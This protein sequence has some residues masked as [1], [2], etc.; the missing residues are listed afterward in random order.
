[1]T[2]PDIISR[3]HGHAVAGLFV[4][5]IARYFTNTMDLWTTLPAPFNV[6]SPTQLPGSL[7]KEGLKY[8]FACDVKQGSLRMPDVTF[9]L[10]DV[11]DTTG[12]RFAISAL[13]TGM[14]A[15]SFSEL[16]ATLTAANVTS[17]SLKDT[18]DTPFTAPG[19]AYVNLEAMSFGS[20]TATA[21][22]T[23]V[24]GLY[25]SKAIT[26]TYD[27]DPTAARPDGGLVPEVTDRPVSWYG[28]RVWLAIAERNVS[29]TI[30]TPQIVW[31]GRLKG[32][33]SLAADGLTWELPAESIWDAQ[34]T[35]I[36]APA[37]ATHING[38]RLTDAVSFLL[39]SAG[40]GAILTIPAATYT[41]D[42]LLQVMQELIQAQ[43]D[44]FATGENH[45]FAAED[46]AIVS[47][48]V[49]PAGVGTQ[50]AIEFFDNNAISDKMVRAFF[51]LGDDGG[52]GD[53]ISLSHDSTAPKVIA[54]L[55][56]AVYRIST[57]GATTLPVEDSSL[58][59]AFEDQDYDEE[60]FHVASAVMIGDSAYRLTAVGAD[61]L[62][63]EPFLVTL[64]FEDRV[65]YESD[66]PTE[67]REG[68]WLEGSLWKY[69]KDGFVENT[70]VPAE[71]KGGVQTEDFD[72]T[73]MQANVNGG[74]STSRDRLI[75]KPT[76][77]KDILLED[78]AWSGLVPTIVDGLISCR[79]MQKA[80]AARVAVALDNDAHVSQ[81]IHS[82]QRSVGNVVNQI[83]WNMVRENTRPWRGA[84]ALAYS[85]TLI[86]NERTSQ[87]R[88]GGQV[89][90]RKIEGSG[91]RG[92]SGNALAE[93]CAGLA[94]DY[95]QLAARDYPVITVEET[96]I[97][98]GLQL[99]DSVYLSH[100]VTPNPDAPN[101]RGV[102]NA[103]CLVTGLTIAPLTG[104][105]EVELIYITDADRAG[106]IAPAARVLDY[107]VDAAIGAGYFTVDTLRYSDVAEGLWFPAN[108]KV[109]LRQWDYDAGGPAAES[110]TLYST[111]SNAAGDR[112]YTTTV[113]ANDPGTAG[114]TWVLTLNEYDTAAQVATAKLYIHIADETTGLIGTSGELG[115]KPG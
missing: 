94:I 111:P 51:G 40:N 2:W 69:L 37:P 108:A 33:L 80:S 71:W 43:I 106:G 107:V 30:D 59:Q 10:K 4:E 19:V 70:S 79:V 104:A 61:T 35:Q 16:T 6:R 101:E 50:Y 53:D 3:G 77:F 97:A 23:L 112:I 95:F 11:N 52:A 47:R 114:G 36:L 44:V 62:T 82:F 56:R 21:A 103:L 81:K 74:G 109:E 5:G 90:S 102:E 93:I 84:E 105:V 25:G 12:A 55:P 22:T 48:Q 72:W 60:W 28:R 63:V 85:F 64:G 38:I 34:D 13:M 1:M 76:S 98:A 32:D 49:E 91:I 54:R 99:M 58:F 83:V 15:A 110:L 20:A 26:H 24:R 78:M 27:P 96:V 92:L 115:F 31:K 113:P 68:I 18:P 8:S 29:G 73:D 88:Y 9:H 7:D 14:G 45:Q 86:T 46:G 75:I 39:F 89:T 100:W 67:V 57:G 87:Q 65:E 66:P 41:A 42:G 17:I